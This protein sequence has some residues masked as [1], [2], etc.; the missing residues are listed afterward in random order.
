MF[1]QLAVLYKS[2]FNPVFTSR[3]FSIMTQK[4]FLTKKPRPVTAPQV[5][6]VSFKNESLVATHHWSR[7][8]CLCTQWSNWYL[9]SPDWQLSFLLPL[10]PQQRSQVPFLKETA[11]TSP[12]S[13]NQHFTKWKMGYPETFQ[14]Q[15][16]ESRERR[17]TKRVLRL[18]FWMT[19]RMFYF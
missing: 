13:F 11:V 3:F 16:G 4:H 8:K 14:R 12:N 17:A 5:L 19:P 2:Q 15:A 6:W 9:W 1:P 7:E 10:V 18:I